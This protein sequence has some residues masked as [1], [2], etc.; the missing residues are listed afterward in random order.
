[1]APDKETFW[2]LMNLH[3]VFLN[4]SLLR[5]NM[6]NSPI[7]NDAREF[8]TSD[9]ERFERMWIASLYVLVEAWNS[10]AMKGVREYIASKVDIQPV[11]SILAQG[12][13]D[14][15]LK[16][17]GQTRH[18]MFHRDKRKYWD[19]GRS[20]PWDQLEYHERLHMTFSTVFLSVFREIEQEDR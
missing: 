11:S 12:Y 16:K 19:I 17:M 6:I 9:R 14:G 2:G 15:S 5:K 18:Y 13:K 10:L 8:D 4:A 7:I 3:D 20:S 1:M